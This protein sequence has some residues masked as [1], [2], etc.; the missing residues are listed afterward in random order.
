MKTK[1]GPSGS[2]LLRP[3]R[4]MRAHVL[5]ALL[6]LVGVAVGILVIAFRYTSAAELRRLEGRQ[7][8]E[9]A[10]L[11]YGVLNS[12]LAI[13][14]NEII[15]FSN[16]DDVYYYLID[17][18]PTGGVWWLVSQGFNILAD[19]DLEAVL[20]MLANGTMLNGFMRTSNTTQGAFRVPVSE[21]LARQIEAELVRNGEA[22]GLF[23]IPESGAAVLVESSY[24]RRSDNTGDDVGWVVYARNVQALLSRAAGMSSLCIQFLTDT[25]NYTDL[26][27]AWTG[28]SA[29]MKGTLAADS[30]SHVVAQSSAFAKTQLACGRAANKTK[31]T[32]LATGT[33]LSDETGVPRLS[34]LIRGLRSDADTIDPSTRYMTVI[35]CGALVAI[36]CLV[37]L[38]MEA[39][40]LRTLSRL[41]SKIVDVSENNSTGERLQLTGKTELRNVT[42]AVNELL[43]ALEH[44]TEQTEHILR[45]I[46]PTEVL[47]RI[48]RGESNNLTF[49]ATCVLFVDICNFTLWSSALAPDIVT[50]YLNGLYSQMDEIVHREG[51][52]KIM[53]IGDAYVVA[54]GVEESSSR[55]C[56]QTMATVALKFARLCHGNVMA[57]SEQPLLFRMGIASGSC[58]SAM[59]GLRKRFYELWGP[60]VT[61]SQQIQESASPGEILVCSET[62]RA[63]EETNRGHFAFEP[64]ET[65]EQG[66]AWRLVATGDTPRTELDSAR[67]LSST[68]LLSILAD[69][70]HI[71]FSDDSEDACK[72]LLRS[73]RLGV[74]VGVATLLVVSV[75]ALVAFLMSTLSSTARELVLHRAMADTTRASH[76]LSE[77]LKDLM[78]HKDV[79]VDYVL[80]GDPNGFLW[81]LLNIT[82][83]GADGVLFFNRNG[84]LFSSIGYNYATQSYRNISSLEVS[85]LSRHL[86]KADIPWGSEMIGQV[87]GLL[88]DP[89]NNVARLAASFPIYYAANTPVVGWVVYLRDI[90]RLLPDKA[91]MMNMCLGALYSRDSSPGPLRNFWSSGRAIA[92]GEARLM[93]V[94]MRDPELLSD[95]RSL[96]G[97]LSG[98]G[99]AILVFVL[100]GSVCIME[101]LVFR[102]LSRLSRAIID[103]T[104]KTGGSTVRF[105]GNDQLLCIAYSVN[106]LLACRAA[107]HQKSINLIQSLF[108]PHVFEVLQ[109]GELPNESYKSTS[110]LF[111]DI[112]GFRVWATATAPEEVAAFLGT[113]IDSLD[114]AAERCGVTKIKTILDIYTRLKAKAQ[115]G[116]VLCDSKTWECTHD[117]FAFHEPQ[118]VQ[119]KG[120][121]LQTVYELDME[122]GSAL[123]SLKLFYYIWLTD[124]PW[125]RK[126][127]ELIQSLFPPHVFEVLQQGKLPNESFK[128]ASIPF[129]DIAGFRD[130]ATATAPE[131]VAAFLGAFID[132]LD[133]AAERCG[134]LALVEVPV[135]L[136]LLRRTAL[137]LGSLAEPTREQN[138]GRARF[139]LVHLGCQLAACGFV[140]SPALGPSQELWTALWAGWSL[141][142]AFA[143]CHAALL[144]DRIDA[145]H[146]TQRQPL[147]AGPCDGVAVLISAVALFGVFAATSSLADLAT[148]GFTHADL[149]V[150]LQSCSLVA[151]A[152]GQM[153]RWLAWR[154]R[155]EADTLK[156]QRAHQAVQA[157]LCASLAAQLAQQ[158]QMAAIGVHQH[159]IWALAFALLSFVLWQ[160]LSRGVRSFLVYRSA[161]PRVAQRGTAHLEGETPCALCRRDMHVGVRLP[162]G[163]AFHRAC[164]T[165]WLQLCTECPLCRFDVMVD[166][167]LYGEWA[168]SVRDQRLSE[169]LSSA[170]D[171]AARGNHARAAQCF[172]AAAA[173]VSDTLG[174]DWQRRRAHMVMEAVWLETGVPREGHGGDE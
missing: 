122:G 111:C 161:V 102:G 97:R 147:P 28:R 114:G 46:Y 133:G 94:A 70:L 3:L 40:V 171:H 152:V 120:K 23:W 41:S 145:C 115:V 121:G 148:L 30:V 17:A 123:P 107:Q 34:V 128:A 48:K 77:S 8:L 85:V 50:K 74:V 100:A 87:L 65:S 66:T 137:A 7:A 52:T 167:D 16:W 27:R 135:L 80:E 151:E 98:M 156:T 32:Y 5:A 20:F 153:V 132:A 164:M 45:S 138:V 155:W 22:S 58:S 64:T 57:A 159:S 49:P 68:G 125:L 166:A 140:W 35:C 53:T 124:F 18:N 11:L 105:R 12:Q 39:F 169:H 149:C 92:A 26:R 142:L 163:H 91:Q 96:S 157:A 136:A 118:T 88:Y 72:R 36:L 106:H 83:I 154:W 134:A 109:Q 54:T 6:V 170:K 69:D 131:E 71:V 51:A 144:H 60:S 158:M 43:A 150:L 119:L 110:I 95:L 127:V 10:T 174:G 55:H 59:I 116:T 47:G 15:S 112:A 78:W 25:A 160:R 173:C 139:C 165:Q 93:M 31:D 81:H 130:W 126:S 62:K 90:A 168:A 67:S 146:A 14:K 29:R 86:L 33:V 9:E 117:E 44:R 38:L 82:S 129:C 104:S 19:A 143:R 2:A 108:P 79:T 42:R 162:C 103:V 21:E 113:F 75:A 56:S 101:L 4:H 89:D 1:T 37:A 141:L 13:L 172:R 99:A 73:L 24:S 76:V 84:T 61:L 63:L